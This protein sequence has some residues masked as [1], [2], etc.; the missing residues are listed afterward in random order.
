MEKPFR[1]PG[2]LFYMGFCSLAA[3]F[4]LFYL[5]HDYERLARWYL[6]LNPCIYRGAQWQQA[7]F[8]PQ[9]KAAGN[10]YAV[11]ALLVIAGLSGYLAWARGR[12]KTIASPPATSPG[13]GEFGFRALLAATGVALWVFSNG[14][15]RPA[16]DEIFSAVHCAGAHPFQALSYYMLPNNHL[17]FNT[18]NSL[19]FWAEDK[20]WSGRLL[21]LAAFLVFQQLVFLWLRRKMPLAQ[22]LGAALLLS[23]A[24]PTLGFAS[25][26]R[27]YGLHLMAGWLAFGAF[28]RYEESG[29]KASSEWMVWGIFLGYATLPSF[30]YF[31]LALAGYGLYAQLSRRRFDAG[32][33]TGHAAAL[34]L[35][36]VF[37]LPVLCFSGWEALAGNKYVRMGE[38]SP[39]DFLP[40]LAGL[41]PFFADYSFYGLFG[42]NKVLLLLAYAAPLGFVF[43]AKKEWRQMAVFYLLLW[44][45]AALVVILMK[46]I[47]FSRNLII[48]YS[49]SQAVMVYFLYVVCTSWKRAFPG[50]VLYWALT[51]ALG[52]YFG[53]RFP[54][55]AG[56]QLYFN[57]ANAIFE[58]NSRDIGLLP[59]D[60]AI[61]FSDESFY[62][63]Y[64]C[65]KAGYR[66]WLCP[67]GGENWWVKR[68]SEPVPEN[69][70]Q[71]FELM[72]TLEADDYEIWKRK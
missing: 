21:S 2:Y 33:W 19:S 64:L 9:V 37:Y 50:Q 51:G 13:K 44:T 69:M 72:H 53:F 38:Q 22:A 49:A 65:R 5:L 68:I 56:E 20:V 11:A 42:G 7:F 58:A 12:T 32:L 29:N 3:V 10:Y 25:Q 40:Q 47:P 61:A 39:A 45:S 17:F 46:K 43:S 31:H 66:A 48:Q 62:W 24:F 6:S 60:A 15:T 14:A 34:G 16:Y 59:K 4:S 52:L 1:L 18:L 71:D 67:Q 35:V 36:F 8:T 23:L 57:R 54:K 30:L 28:Q 70:P 41:L 26:A 27:G 63:Y 55:V